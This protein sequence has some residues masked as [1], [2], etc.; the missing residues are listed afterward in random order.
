MRFSGDSAGDPLGIG[1]SHVE[2]SPPMA[3]KP[4]VHVLDRQPAADLDDR[5]TISEIADQSIDRIH[6]RGVYH[7]ATRVRRH[8]EIRPGMSRTD[9]AKPPVLTYGLLYAGFEFFEVLGMKCS[10]QILVLY[11]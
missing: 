4:I 3:I 5:F 2:K 1:V 8:T 10:F 7:R 9:D 11:C 6:F